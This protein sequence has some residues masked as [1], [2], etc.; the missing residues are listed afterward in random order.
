MNS[1]AENQSR[2]PAPVV[3]GGVGGS[4]TRLIARCLQ[5]LGWRLGEDL[6][7]SLDNMWF[8]L[9][10]K[11]PEVLTCGD[12]E[13]RQL[14]EVLTA[15]T[16]NPSMTARLLIRQLNRL[17]LL[18]R[19]N[20]LR[21]WLR[22]ASHRL[23][24]RKVDIDQGA[25]WGW[26]EP[27]SHI[28]LDRLVTQFPGMKYI[29]VVRNGLDMA[30]SRNDNQL[31]LWGASLLGESCDVSPRNLLKYWCAVQRRAERHREL[32]QDRFLMLNFDDFCM[33]PNHGIRRLTAFL[34][35][36]RAQTT[37]E[38]LRVHIRPPRSIGRFKEHGCD[39]FN[40]EDVAYVRE[41]GFDTVEQET[42]QRDVA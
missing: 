4:G 21:D 18:D 42:P 19:P 5:E 33:N 8:T 38:K 41:L 32:L 20:V 3:I 1:I 2:Y 13:F 39:L 15:A 25:T 17:R 34:G 11:R 12:H 14:A 40:P 24:K 9:L 28:F 10:F 36:D 7:R 22:R 31:K 37:L 6:N 35:F 26:K 29:H 30:H 23:N 16:L 27:N